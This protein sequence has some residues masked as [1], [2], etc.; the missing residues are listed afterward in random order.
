MTACERAKAPP[1]I[2]SASVKPAAAV[3][4]SAAT[5]ARGWNPDVGPVILVAAGSPIQAYV[6]LPGDSASRATL[7]GLPSPASATLLGRTGTVQTGEV[8]SI[9]D[10]GS[11]VTATIGG[12]PP[13]RAWNVGFIG[14][15]VAPLAVDS[16]E[17]FT[18]AD[19]I[20]AVTWLNRLASALPNDSAGRFAGL[21][22]VVSGMWRFNLPDG[23]QVLA[24]NLTRQINQEATPLQEHTFLIAERRASD[25]TFATAYSDRSYGDEETIENHDLLAA[26]LLGGARQPAIVVAR[27]FGDATS[28]GIIERATPGH[29]RIGWFSPKRHC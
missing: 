11:C 19:S 10:S 12:A 23:A 8:P 4:S 25:T 6:L 13:P 24:A 2:D 5:A 20:S 3:D 7:S 26:M 15:V 1:P 28:F 14:G 18:S 29:W 21:P 27:D 9:A 17:S 22:F 16:T